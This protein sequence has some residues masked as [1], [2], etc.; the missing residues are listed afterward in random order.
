MLVRHRSR[1]AG[2]ALIAVLAQNAA[3]QEAPNDQ[4]PRLRIQIDVTATVP[5]DG[6]WLEIQSRDF[7][8]VGTANERRSPEGSGGPR[9]PPRDVRTIQSSHSRHLIGS[10][11]CSRLSKFLVVPLV[12]T[13]RRQPAGQGEGLRSIQREQ[14]LHRDDA[15][16]LHTPRGLSRL[17]A[18][19]DSRSHGAGPAMVS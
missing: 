16:R 15:W 11:D 13:R 6:H 10:D 12:P 18:A 8:V 4:E 9:T 14:E 5:D 17:H 19:A 1:M 2:L 7:V 3:A